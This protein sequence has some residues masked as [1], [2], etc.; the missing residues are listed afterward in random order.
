MLLALDTATDSI[1]L[2]LT[3][4]NRILVEENWVT[5]RHATVELAAETARCCERRRREDNLQGIAL[6]IGPGSY[7]GLRIGLA[8]AK[9]LAFGRGLKVVPV[10]TL[11]VLA[12]GQPPRSERMLAM[13][14]AGR[15]RWTAAWYKW[16]RRAWKSEGETQLIAWPMVEGLLDKPT[17]LC[18]EFEAEERKVL[19]KARNARLAP[20]ELCL[21]RPAVLA[22]IGWARLST[23]QARPPLQLVP[24]Y[25]APLDGA[26]YR[27]S[28]P[29]G[30]PEA[31]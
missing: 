30:E 2:A 1:G 31:A 23:R 10:P 8:F 15:G 21:R 20:V 3:D 19:S 12:A 18:G 7:T 29:A 27:P 16:G 5:R 26:S 22:Q 28:H 14:R 4:G 25:P 17:Y 11:E 9:G 24:V 13:V 6:T